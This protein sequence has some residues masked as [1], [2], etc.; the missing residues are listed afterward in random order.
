MQKAK[1]VK[2]KVLLQTEHELHIQ[3]VNWFKLAYGEHAI[4]NHQ[5]NE[6]PRGT[7]PQYNVKMKLLGTKAGFP[8]LQIFCNAKTILIELKS[9]N[10]KLSENQVAL[11][12]KF[13]AVGFK[14][15]IVRTFEEFRAIVNDFVCGIKA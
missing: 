5:A 3:C 8:D 2:Q 9:L 1:T 15:H 13:Q 4:L 6:N 11:F 14:V 10:G 12:R 7:T